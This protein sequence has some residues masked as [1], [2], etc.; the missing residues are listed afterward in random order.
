MFVAGSWSFCVTCNEPLV[1][2]P[3]LFLSFFLTADFGAFCSTEDK[4]WNFTS[5]SVPPATRGGKRLMRRTIP[6]PENLD[7]I[8]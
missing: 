1:L 3:G 4:V 7:F 5:V 8:C 6:K 2:G